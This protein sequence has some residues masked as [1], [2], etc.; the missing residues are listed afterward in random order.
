MQIGWAVASPSMSAWW[1]AWPAAPLSLLLLLLLLSA[2]LQLLF[3]VAVVE[4]EEGGRIVPLFGCGDD[5]GGGTVEEAAAAA[6]VRSSGGEQEAVEDVDEDEH[7]LVVPVEA[8]VVD[9]IEALLSA[10]PSAPVVTAGAVGSSVRRS[11]ISRSRSTSVSLGSIRLNRLKDGTEGTND[12][13]E[14]PFT[15]HTFTPL[16]YGTR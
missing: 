1:F 4:E 10:L 14:L 9:A 2:P 13:M 7:V 8:E 3:G 12:L 6:A 5:D 15:K 11:A 16:T